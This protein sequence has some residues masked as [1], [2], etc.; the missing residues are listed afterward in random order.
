MRKYLC[1]NSESRNNNVK[2][3]TLV[4]GTYPVV[5][6]SFYHLLVRENNLFQSDITA[7]SRLYFLW[8]LILILPIVLRP[9]LSND[10]Q[11]SQLIELNCNLNEMYIQIRAGY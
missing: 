2:L 10:V 3:E 5:I 9:N 1:N 11:L 8:D 4:L 7:S 6:N